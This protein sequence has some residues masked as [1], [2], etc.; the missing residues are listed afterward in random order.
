MTAYP[1]DQTSAERVDAGVLPMM[2]WYAARLVVLG[3]TA[4]TDWLTRVVLES[5][6]PAIG[7]R[8]DCLPS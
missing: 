8:C 1:L 6:E 4:S 3:V 7:R 5:D 2:V